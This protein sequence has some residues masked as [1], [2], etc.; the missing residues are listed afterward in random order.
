M[1]MQDGACPLHIATQEG[2]DRIVEMLVQA[3]ATVDLQNKVENCHLSLVVCHV[4]YSLYTKHHHNIWGNMK[5]RKHIQQI[6]AADMH[7]RFVHWKNVDSVHGLGACF[8]K[9]FVLRILV[10]VQNCSEFVSY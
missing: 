5:V 6:T 10:C 1:C 9:K 8:P 2:H 7:W 4:H 3:K